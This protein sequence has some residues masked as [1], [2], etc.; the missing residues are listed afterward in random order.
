MKHEKN[1]A[2][3]ASGENAFTA[4]A[5]ASRLDVQSRADV[6]ISGRS[7]RDELAKGK[8][9]VQLTL[10]CARLTNDEALLRKLARERRVSVRV[11]AL[12]NPHTPFDVL[13]GA[14][15]RDKNW[16]VRHAASEAMK[17][18]VRSMPVATA[19]EVLAHA[20]S[21]EVVEEIVQRAKFD[22]AEVLTLLEREFQVANRW[23]REHTVRAADHLAQRADLKRFSDETVLELA[24]QTTLTVVARHCVAAK[25]SG[26]LEAL[27]TMVEA[28]TLSAGRPTDVL[29]ELALAKEMEPSFY[30]RVLAAASERGRSLATVIADNTHAPW[31]L[32]EGEIASLTPGAVGRAL[33][34]MFH[35]AA[36]VW[37]LAAK[38]M[39]NTMTV[40]EVLDVL[41]VTHPEHLRG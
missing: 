2:R 5:L 19:F 13:D 25:R 34:A 8:S 12:Q 21:E 18:R 10:Q 39:E 15:V 40:R 35:D 31:E 26:V 38:L 32:L 7:L 36:A 24:K 14:L 37:L 9:D 41:C 16:D 29:R 17:R 33:Q 22:D 28:G 20:K 3:W 30:R 23:G 4:L 27:L 6:G 11:T 1:L